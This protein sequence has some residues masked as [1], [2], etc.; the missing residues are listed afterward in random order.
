MSN[1]MIFEDIEERVEN[2]VKKMKPTK[3]E[4]SAATD[5]QLDAW[6]ALFVFGYTVIETD[7]CNGE[8]NLW[9]SKDNQH[10]FNYNGFDLELPHYSTSWAAMGEVVERMQK[11]GWSYCADNN[12]GPPEKGW[13]SSFW[14]DENPD[15]PFGVFADTAPRAVAEASVIAVLDGE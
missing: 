2:R 5:R 9:L 12:N 11:L 3:A 7:D 8:D 6:V 4:I 10:V 14:K 15:E 13:Y 1:A